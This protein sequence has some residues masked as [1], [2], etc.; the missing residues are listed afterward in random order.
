MS[1]KEFQTIRIDNFSMVWAVLDAKDFFCIAKVHRGDT[2]FY[3]WGDGETA[4]DARCMCIKC[5][6]YTSKKDWLLDVDV[7]AEKNQV[8]FVSAASGDREIAGT[9]S[10]YRRLRSTQCPE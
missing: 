10:C 9:L 8:V 2:C 4:E 3:F 1:S 7:W 5:I 6:R